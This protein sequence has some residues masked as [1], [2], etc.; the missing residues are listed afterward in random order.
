MKETYL[1]ITNRHQKEVNDFPIAFAFSEEQFEEALE[2]LGAKK[3]ECVT[4]FGS[5]DIVRKTDAKRFTDML[6]RHTKEIQEAMKDEEF[7]E[8]AFLYE[9][10]NHEYAI[11]LSGDEDVLDCFGLTEKSLIEKGLTTAYMRARKRHMKKT[12]EWY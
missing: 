10:D 3:E 12:E 5:G 11:N 9:M 7:A 1:D 2:K 4:I 8:E 6:K